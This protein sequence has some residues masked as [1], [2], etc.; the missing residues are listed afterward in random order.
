MCWWLYA[1]L[2]GEGCGLTVS[3][4]ID[5]LVRSYCCTELEV[6]VVLDEVLLLIVA[7]GEDPI[8]LCEGIK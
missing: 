1:K 7:S 2:L 8:S 6:E 5:M 4:I 3:L